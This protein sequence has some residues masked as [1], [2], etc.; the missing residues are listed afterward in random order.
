[1]VGLGKM[2]ANMAQRLTAGGHEVV[3]FDVDAEAVKR[4]VDKGSEGA[5]SLEE[6]VA[7]LEPPRAVW[8]MVPAGE[9]TERTL[10][11]L[12]SRLS[13]GD[14]IVDG[15][16]S[17][18]TETLTRHERLQSEGIGFV[19]AGTSGGVWGLEEGYC[20]MVGA[21]QSDFDRLEPIFATLAPDNGYARVGRP[22]A[23]HFVKMVH[24]GIEY[25]QMEALGEGFDVLAA[26]E[27]DLDLAQVAEVWRY[28]SVIRSWLLDLGAA[29]LKE[30]PTLEGVSDRIDDSGEGRWT[31]QWAIENAVPADVIA[32]ALF[33]RFAS[34]QDESTSGKLIAALRG[35]FGGHEVHRTG[36]S[37]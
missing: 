9:I 23:G 36:P 3:T 21:A 17:H 28:G 11:E 10:D 4:A 1:M 26:G 34:R 14:V 16:N 31:V 2:G 30:N 37:G 32:T 25:A 29:A 7:A 5:A 19:D 15:G 6:L 13:E 8:I 27:F 24:N 12:G 18:Y 20:L 33:K 35:Q 22:G